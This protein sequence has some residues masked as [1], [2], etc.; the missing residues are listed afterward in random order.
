MSTFS[1]AR[2]WVMLCLLVT[3]AARAADVPTFVVET[4]SGSKGNAFIVKD[5]RPGRLG[6]H[7]LVT[8]LHVLHRMSKIA[9]MRVDCSN[10][11]SSLNKVAQ[12]FSEGTQVLTWPQ[13]DLAAI[14]IAPY[15][16]LDQEQ[17]GEIEF[18]EPDLKG[19][20][21]VN[22]HG[23]SSLSV[24][25]EGMGFLMGR[26]VAEKLAKH[27]E[28]LGQSS[29]GSIAGHVPLFQYFSPSAPGTSGAAVTM[30]NRS[31]MVIG[32]HNAGYVGSSVSWA[33]GFSGQRSALATP[34]AIA[35]LG[36]DD[37][38][39]FI[40]PELSQA[41]ALSVFPEE[42][43]A[44]ARRSA[45]QNFL[46][47]VWLLETATTVNLTAQAVRCSF[48]YEVRRFPSTSQSTGLGLRLSA[49]YRWAKSLESALGPEGRPLWERNVWAKGLFLEPEMELRFLRLSQFRPALGISARL[50]YA[51]SSLWEEPTE[52][53]VGALA[54][55]LRLYFTP[56]NNIPLSILAELRLARG[57]EIRPEHRYTGIGAEVMT[58]E[59]SAVWLMGG[60]L[61]VVY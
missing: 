35:H 25:Q 54:G 44:S 23:T 30:P 12:F 38:P 2:N 29:Q 17:A 28:S 6:R 1:A 57:H 27:L 46:D 32:I 21:F 33:V 10:A 11:T 53:E 45:R 19:V 60:A 55:N 7:L 39:L 59:S 49:G 5:W 56:R 13:Y 61:G 51:H 43:Q 40:K 9:I 50:W 3:G 22:I 36:K 26:P 34:Q 24:C 18:N 37:W 4:N 31:K 42:T 14:E 48:T 20:Y 16:T 15:A 47:C 52:L 8:A 58:R 41:F